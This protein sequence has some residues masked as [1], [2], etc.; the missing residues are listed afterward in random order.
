MWAELDLP[1]QNG[2]AVGLWRW[3]CRAALVNGSGLS[4]ERPRAAHVTCAIVI[5][6]RCLTVIFFLYILGLYQKN[7]FLRNQ[8][9]DMSEE[10]YYYPFFWLV[11]INKNIIISL[12]FTTFCR[13]WMDDLW[14]YVLFN[15]ISV[16]SGRCLDD[17]ERLCAMELRLRLRRF[18][19]EWGSNSVRTFCRITWFLQMEVNMRY[20]ACSFS[21]GNFLV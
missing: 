5:H 18:H 8:N 7:R 4:H 19:L 21:T 10:G 17:N 9:D 11:F 2:A 13:W 1:R 12:H 6:V 14:F 15:S 20:F 3:R 16:I